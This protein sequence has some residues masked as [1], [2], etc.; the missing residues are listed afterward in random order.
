MRDMI[1][2]NKAL[3]TD[4]WGNENPYTAILDG[5]VAGERHYSHLPRSGLQYPYR[6][7][8]FSLFISP[9]NVNSSKPDGFSRTISLENFEKPKELNENRME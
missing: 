1:Y 8:T 2:S 5:M 3:L 4:F 7:R 9:G 6:S